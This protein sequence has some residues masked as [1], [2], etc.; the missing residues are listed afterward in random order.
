MSLNEFE[1][2]CATGEA[3]DPCT[4]EQ[5]E[6]AEE[7]LG[8]EFPDQYRYF[9]SKYGAILVDGGELYGLPNPQKNDP[10]L[11]C[12][13]VQ[14]TTKL[15]ARNQAGSEN[16]DL[17][18]ISDD[19]TGVYFFLDTASS[20]STKILAIGPGISKE[21]EYDVFSFLIAQSAGEIRL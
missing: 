16:S 21:L 6:N 3:S 8:V 12:D 18:P 17:I 11:W 7:V 1:A 14:S 15:R 9:L 20:T 2:L 19:G 13:V 10:P 4:A 5:I